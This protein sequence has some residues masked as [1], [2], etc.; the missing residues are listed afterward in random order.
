M[1][2]PTSIA[3]VEDHLPTALLWVRVVHRAG[4]ACAGRFA[5]AE[6]AW[7]VL[8]RAPPGLVLL[9]WELPGRNGGWLAVRL[10]GLDPAVPI[11]VVTAHDEPPVLREAIGVPVNGFVRKPVGPKEL[12]QRIR[13]V[14]A[15]DMPMNTRHGAVLHSVTSVT[16]VSGASALSPREREIVLLDACGDTAKEMAEKL[17]ISIHTIPTYKA[18][19]TRKL[20][21]RHFKEAVAFAAGFRNW[22]PPACPPG[23]GPSG[24]RPAAA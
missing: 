16:S 19:I 22:Y 4:Y 6:S 2:G 3:I 1:S 20:H 17:Q 24:A 11:L 12:L 21:A 7:K 23:N 5:D 15:G 14:L 10:H 18:R 9:D 8:R 13:E